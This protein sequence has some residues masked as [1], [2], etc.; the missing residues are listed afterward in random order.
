MYFIWQEISIS[1]SFRRELDNTP[2]VKQSSYII[3]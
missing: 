2:D 3:Q 1:F